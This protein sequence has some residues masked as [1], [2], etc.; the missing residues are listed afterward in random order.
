MKIYSHFVSALKR[1]WTTRLKLPLLIRSRS[2]ASVNPDSWKK[3]LF[4]VVVP[5]WKG[6]PLTHVR[7]LSCRYE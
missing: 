6:D 1:L 2:S 3:W 4:H 5:V 7:I